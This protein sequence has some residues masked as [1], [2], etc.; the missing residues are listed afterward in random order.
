MVLTQS[1]LCTGSACIGLT[2][3][4]ITAEEL[5]KMQAV[6]VVAK[7]RIAHDSGTTRSLRQ[8]KRN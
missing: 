7:T 3:G 6:T 2:A 8:R 5:E 4:R 1:D